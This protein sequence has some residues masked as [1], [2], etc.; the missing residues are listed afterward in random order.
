MAPYTVRTSKGTP[1][2]A[3]QKLAAIY[4]RVSTTDQADKGY[5]LPTQI[6]ACR[7]FARREG[8]TVQWAFQEDY[9]GTSLNR[10]Q[11]KALRE[12]VR[13]RLLEAVIIYDQDRLSRKLAHQLLLCDE[14]EECGV[15]LHVVSMPMND[16]SPEGQL[17]SNVRGAFDEYERL[18]ILKRTH[19]GRLGR[20][21]AGFPSGGTVP[22]GYTYVKHVHQGAH[23]EINLEEAAL[24]ERIF[25]MYVDDGLSLK[26]IAR[27]LTRDKVPSCWDRRSYRLPRKY[28]AGVWYESAVTRILSNTA[29]IGTL[30]WGKHE[31]QRSPNNPDKK[32]AW[33]R[34]P[35]DE[36]FAISVPAIIPQDLFDA[37]QEKKQ[38]NAQN[39]RRN[40]KHEYLLCNARL[41]CGRCGY[42]MAGYCLNNRDWR[43]YR[44]SRPKHLTAQPCYG[45][46]G[47]NKLE[48]IVWTAIEKV[49]RQP[50][51]IA[52]EVERRK[53]GVHTEQNDL[54][55]ERRFYEGQIAQCDKELRK[56]EQAYITDAI[57]VHDFKTK[58]AE[59]MTR[60]ASLERE[61]ARLDEQQQ[62]LE[63]VELETASLV[64]YCQRVRETLHQFDF[65]EK[66]HA[67]D[68]LNI[69][70]VWHPDKPLE[71][72]G[73]VPVE[74]QESI[75]GGID[76]HAIRR[77]VSPDRIW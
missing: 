50:E 34:K 66:R 39:C 23:D 76:Y 25:R 44:C 64:E 58:K 19:D 1:T 32:T 27:Q 51:L 38:R 73:S 60:R 17:F 48:T 28:G 61:M 6:E 40:R 77:R 72:Q 35:Q 7:E 14:M 31:R 67:L 42:V 4:A 18:K 20:V 68:A 22:L 9:T 24:V 30:Y 53:Y 62:L 12:I 47:A 70:V 57:D 21:K 43:F 36:W 52:V 5:S 71:I 74:T 46:I 8:Y 16:K 55:R 11:L 15:I 49:L 54:E 2:S 69:S 3:T 59:V 63:Q 10:P 41:R 45:H 56:W 26:E 13:Q 29:Y 33:R 37:A 75:S 65:P